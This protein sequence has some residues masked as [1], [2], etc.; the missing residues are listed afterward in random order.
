MK[1]LLGALYDVL[2]PEILKNKDSLNPLVAIVISNKETAVNFLYGMV[3][4]YAASFAEKTTASIK[5]SEMYTDQMYVKSDLYLDSGLLS[6]K[7]AIEALLPAQASNSQGLNAI[8]ITASGESWNLNKPVK[9]DVYAVTGDSLQIGGSESGKLLNPSKLLSLF[10]KQSIAYLTFREDLQL[11]RKRL[12][13]KMG[14]DAGLDPGE[15]GKPFI[16]NGSTLVPVRYVVEQ[17]DAEVKWDSSKREVT[18][19]DELTGNI[20]VFKIDSKTALLN[21]NV[22]TLDTEAI[23]NSG[24]STYVPVRFIIE[25]GL[26]GTISWDDNTRTVSIA[27]D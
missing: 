13:M 22:V 19:K 1:E 15:S 9:A 4:E 21:G 20:I 27:R 5:T 3:Q 2:A 12:S 23:I 26:S 11:T 14:Q 8:K 10:G 25:Q 17:L 18:V 16:K 6:R 24:G 7:L